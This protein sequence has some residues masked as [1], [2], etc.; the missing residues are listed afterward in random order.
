[1]TTTSQDTAIAF[2]LASYARLENEHDPIVVRVAQPR[3]PMVRVKGSKTGRTVKVEPQVAQPAASA[4]KPAAAVETVA[5]PATPSP[6]GGK[7][8]VALPAAG[9][10]GAKAFTAM[11]N[12]SK[13]REESIIAIASFIG[14]DNRLTFADNEMAA[15]Q[16]AKAEL[17][18]VSAT[19]PSREEIRAA[20]RSA[21]GYVA[22]MPDAAG[23]V[24]RDLLG[25]EQYAVDERNRLET[26]QK[27]TD[28]SPA[29]RQ[30][31]DGLIQL[32]NERLVQIRAD[33]A[34]LVG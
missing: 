30:L 34:K 5:K 20:Q 2:A 14:Y 3:Q 15:K 23:K 12:R 13:S 26:E 22:G 19:G 27:R 7:A 10:I 33:I 9:T 6:N 25:R 4:A 24:I 16:A 28:L 32:E 11:M 29:E 1:M 18:P 31:N 8:V 21:T 17:R